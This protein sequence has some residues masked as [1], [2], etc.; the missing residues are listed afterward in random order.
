M[1]KNNACL[2]LLSFGLFSLAL[3]AQ[4]AP[5]APAEDGGAYAF[6]PN[7]AQNP[8][9]SPEAY[10]LL[11]ERCAANAAALGLR[12][13]GPA[14]RLTTALAW[15][16][17]AANGLT[18]CSY[19]AIGA[20]VDHNAAAGA[21]TDF[22]CGARTYDGH[23]G[24]DIGIPPFS[25]YKMD[26]NQVEVIAA[27][28]GV[29]LDKADGNFD[30]NCSANN[31]PAN[32]AV[33]Q[34]PDGSRAL[35]WHMKK[36]SV[37]TKAI[38]QPIAAGEYLGVVGSSGSSSGP[39]LHFEVWSGS[40]ASTRVDPYSGACNTLNA[41]SWWAAQK[42]Y[43][44]PAIVKASVHTT[45]IVLPGCPN[46]ETPNE[47]SSFSIPFQG[48]GL[49]AGWAKF[50]IFMRDE[51]AGLT[52]N[53][54]IL[55]PNGSTFSSWTYNSTANNPASWRG[56]TKPLPT[57]A[58]TY[59]FVATYNGI[60]C[61]KAFDITTL[62]QTQTFPLPE[63]RPL[64]VVPN[65]TTGRCAVEAGDGRATGGVVEI[66]NM[67]GR[68]VLTTEARQI[69]T[70]LDLTGQPGGVYIVS[71]HSAKGNQTARVLKL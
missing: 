1:R 14:G 16:L 9:I 66:Y 45:D 32:Y 3:P 60:T 13:E 2:L 30:R 34:H 41:S 25:F 21:V 43:A 61:S 56:W 27:A 31:L 46:T 40:T 57:T 64:V 6:E 24:T 68:R 55:N 22:H 20:Y 63:A 69:S 35:Y 59:T 8:C 17:R 65:P 48:A 36:N 11:E 37:T 7:D 52:A 44:E 33:I 71:V 15:P 39:H 38:G 18:D 58:G 12:V 5:P 67:L 23:Q 28:A 70:E 4:D 53:L 42:P 50:Y 62:V 47:S 29:L 26:H 49:P 10:A 19:Y 54:S 51:T